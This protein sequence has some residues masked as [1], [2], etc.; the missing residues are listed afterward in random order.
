MLL[1]GGVGLGNGRTHAAPVSCSLCS[2]ED[3]HSR[4]YHCAV[5]YRTGM[6]RKAG[7]VFCAP[8]GDGSAG[9][10]LEVYELV[11]GTSVAKLSHAGSHSAVISRA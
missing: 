6:M 2:G 4:S 3:A 1:A 11:S 8:L 5:L 9:N 10:P 7:N